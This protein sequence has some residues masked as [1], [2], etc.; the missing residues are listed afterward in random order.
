M[1]ISDIESVNQFKKNCSEY[2]I[3]IYTDKYDEFLEKV[4]AVY[5]ALRMRHII[6]MQK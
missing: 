1:P 2:E 6:N 5:I 4:D 3:D